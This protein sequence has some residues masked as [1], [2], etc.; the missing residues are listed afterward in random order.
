MKQIRKRSPLEEM[1]SNRANQVVNGIGLRDWDSSPSEIVRRE[2]ALTLV[3]IRQ[4][5]RLDHE[6][7]YRRLKIESYVG[8][9]F[10]RME[11]N[12]VPNYEHKKYQLH[13]QLQE[14]ELERW[15]QKLKRDEKL[16]SLNDRLLSLLNKHVQLDF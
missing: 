12:R 10:L 13:R 4:V 14:L 16:Q 7:E 6:L 11:Y 9:Q 5:K 3:H 15:K 8:N 2:I 1:L